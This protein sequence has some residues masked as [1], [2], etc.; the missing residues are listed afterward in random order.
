MSRTAR[1]VVKAWC[2]A[3]YEPVSPYRTTAGD[4]FIVTFSGSRSGAYKNRE[5][6]TNHHYRYV[7]SALR[8]IT[9]PLP[10]VRV[11]GER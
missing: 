8:R 2:F 1:K 10:R 11:K 9:L 6:W 4:P 3:C 7:V 5:G